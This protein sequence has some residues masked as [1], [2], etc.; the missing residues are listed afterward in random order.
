MENYYP[1]LLLYPGRKCASNIGRLAIQ[2]QQS[3]SLRYPISFSWT[4]K[5]PTSAVPFF[6]SPFPFPPA[7]TV[8]GWHRFQARLFVANSTPISPR[9]IVD[10]RAS[11]L[12]SPSYPFSLIERKRAAVKGL[13]EGEERYN[14]KGR[15]TVV[16]FRA[17]TTL[18][19]FLD[20]SSLAFDCARVG[21]GERI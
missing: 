16:G 1:Y 11:S 17:L 7:Y 4:T 8:R 15:R 13:G 5:G 20:K 14:N 21:V 19:F 10:T 2:I 9:T 6:R 12:L 18:T 3:H